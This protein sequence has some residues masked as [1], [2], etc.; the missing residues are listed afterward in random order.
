MQEELRVEFTVNNENKL[1]TRGEI[2]PYNF[3][4]LFSASE[5]NS[6]ELIWN[7]QTRQELLA[8]LQ[9]QV[10]TLIAEEIATKADQMDVASQSQLSSGS[11]L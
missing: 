10:D 6:P 5:F 11:G 8:V 2:S 1:V 7:D 9:E 3:L 4:N